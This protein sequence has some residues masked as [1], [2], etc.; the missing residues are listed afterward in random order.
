[1]KVKQK[2]RCRGIGNILRHLF[3]AERPMD[4]YGIRLIYGDEFLFLF[5]RLCVFLREGQF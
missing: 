5:L 1:M 3:S 2:A 4:A